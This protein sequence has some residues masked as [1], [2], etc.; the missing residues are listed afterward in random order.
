MFTDA[1][2]LS[3]GLKM[4]VSQYFFP[5]YYYD[6]MCWTYGFS[7]SKKELSAL[8]FS[9]SSVLSEY[10]FVSFAGKNLN[11]SGQFV[12]VIGLY[13][14]QVSNFARVSLIWMCIQCRLFPLLSSETLKIPACCLASPLVSV[15][16][17]G[18]SLSSIGL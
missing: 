1:N 10:S 18:E 3:W 12:N 5:S 13:K 8:L 11:F 4:L 17:A 6:S 7:Y 9:I 14:K 15:L 2:L 16:G